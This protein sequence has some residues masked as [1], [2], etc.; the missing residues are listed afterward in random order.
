M[1]YILIAIG[2]GGSWLSSQKTLPTSR[3]TVQRPQA[4]AWAGT[5]TRKDWNPHHFLFP[6]TQSSLHKL[7][8]CRGAEHTSLPGPQVVK[9]E[10]RYRKKVEH[11]QA[12][13][14]L[15]TNKVN[16]QISSRGMSMGVPESRNVL[17]FSLLS[18]FWS[19]CLSCRGLSPF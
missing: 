2:H 1:M 9:T 12:R 10:G 6:P 11:L 8:L 19:L 3:A 15:P 18:V 7:G 4:W 5:L 16:G 13:L 14:R 17:Q